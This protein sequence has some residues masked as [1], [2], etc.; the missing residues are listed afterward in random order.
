ML[1]LALLADGEN[2]PRLNGL[3]AGA[4]FGV[5]KSKQFLKGVRVGRI[6]E[7]CPFTPHVHQILVF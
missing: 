1:V 6:P 4:T 7:E 2:L 3:V 5:Q